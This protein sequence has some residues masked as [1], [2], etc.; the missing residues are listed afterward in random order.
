MCAAVDCV[1]VALPLYFSLDDV[2]DRYRS[3][4][5]IDGVTLRSPLRHVSGHWGRTADRKRCSVPIAS[6]VALPLHINNYFY[7]C[8]GQ[9]CIHSQWRGE[10]GDEA[11]VPTFVSPSPS[12]SP[13]LSF[14]HTLPPTTPLL[15]LVCTES[16]A[17]QQSPCSPHH[18]PRPTQPI[19]QY[20]S[21]TGSETGR[22]SWC[23]TSK[24]RC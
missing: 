12:L 21:H 4:V 6:S 8:K 20:N 18:F 11:R 22:E 9:G 10:P 19:G 7:R 14:P 15:P 2:I 24:K 17:P 1:Y 16:N 3:E 13:S 5:I 23:T